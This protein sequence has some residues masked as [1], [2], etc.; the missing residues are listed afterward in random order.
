MPHARIVS[1]DSSTLFS[2]DGTGPRLRRQR[3]DPR[4]DRV[5][6][7]YENK[8]TSFQVCPFPKCLSF[9]VSEFL[10]SG[11]VEFVSFCASEFPSVRVSEL[12]S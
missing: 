12:L 8:C 2:Y 11:H 6:A 9:S 3:C 1:F 7:S 4:S 10:A 5:R